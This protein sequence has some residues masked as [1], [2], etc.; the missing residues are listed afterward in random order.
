MVRYDAFTRRSRKY[1]DNR[2]SGP[3]C[4]KFQPKKVWFLVGFV[5]A[6]ITDPWRIQEVSYV[7]F[8]ILILY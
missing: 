2:P 7:Y 4:V 6:Q 1:I 5:W 8:G 3:I